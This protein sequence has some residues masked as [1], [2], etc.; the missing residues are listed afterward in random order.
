MKKVIA[1]LAIAILAS[2]ATMQ[3]QQA[4]EPETAVTKYQSVDA[5][6][7]IPRKAEDQEATKATITGDGEEVRW[8]P[9]KIKVNVP[10][11]NPDTK[12]AE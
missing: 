4:A 12:Q 1:L 8:V 9:L 3:P 10:V 6:V 11:D 7:L 2:C 5:Y